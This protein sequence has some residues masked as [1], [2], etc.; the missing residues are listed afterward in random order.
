MRR[1]TIRWLMG[2]FLLPLFPG[3]LLAQDNNFP[4]ETIE[5]TLSG[6][7]CFAIIVDSVTFSQ[8]KEAIEL[9][10]RSVEEDGLPTYIL[11]ARW[12]HPEQVRHVIRQL[13]HQENSRLEG[14]VLVGEIPIVLLGGA[15]HLT[16]AF[17][18]DEDKFPPPRSYVPTDRFYDDLDLDCEYVGQDSID[19]LIH[20]YTL[21]STSPAVVQRELYS[22]RIRTNTGNGDKHDG[23]K[24]FFEKVA[25]RKS[26]PLEPLDQVVTVY[27]YGYLSDSYT[28]IMDE[29]EALRQNLSLGTRAKGT[30]LSLFHLV[31]PNLKEQLLRTITRNNWDLFLLHCHGRVTKQFIE[32]EKNLTVTAFP[33][34]FDSSATDTTIGS[35]GE[36]TKLDLVS[37]RLGPELI[38]LD[39]CYNGAFPSPECLAMNYLFTEGEVV[40]VVGNSVNVRQD[41]TFMDELGAVRCGVRIGTWHQLQPYLESHLFGDPTFR[42]ART[43]EG[44]HKFS[45]P[46]QLATPE[47][48]SEKY[49]R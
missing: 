14:V 47:R 35:P 4:L 3:G 8:V 49:L 27:G 25:L 46:F 42:F 31:H 40:A 28:A 11:V 23:L 20:Y 24:R 38:I 18:M 7:T 37:R 39:V 26:R 2:V 5:P 22:A 45:P 15:Q 29:V 6:P 30:V 19:T 44:K 16:S 1:L 41:V 13:C 10:R 21:R 33:A 12:S 43:L 34:E 17:K 9:Y 32:V 48:P 36:L